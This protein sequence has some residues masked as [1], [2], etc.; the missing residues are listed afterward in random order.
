M[1]NVVYDN[2][3]KEYKDS[4]QLP[5]R[6]YIESYTLFQIA[7]NLN[8]LQV[9]DLACGEGFYTR[10]LKEAGAGHVLG[11]DI[12]SEMIHLA[13]ASEKV[14]PIGCRYLVHD[15][16]TLPH[17]GSFDLVVAMYLLNYAQTR[18][19]LFS[20]C[21]AAYDQLKPGGRFVGFNDNLYNDP[22]KYET[23]RKYGF[24]KQGSSNRKEGDPIRYTFYNADGTEFQFNNY[25]LHPNNYAEA[26]AAAGFVDFEWKGA[27]LSP[28][29]R[30]NPFWDDFMADPPIAGF[31]ALKT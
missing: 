2:I 17:I 28:A 1:E 18:E 14:D 19:Q 29:E 27:Y 31:S 6:R 26:F 3:A 12:S 4:K 16:A 7:G 22:S 5:F 13:E 10:K 11:V 20:F 30:A 15:V 8:G 25:Y 21:K 23:Y 9:I 24:I